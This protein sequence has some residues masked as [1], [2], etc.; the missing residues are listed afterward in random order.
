MAD[1]RQWQEGALHG[2]A[3]SGDRP[4]EPR[5]VKAAPPFALSHTPPLRSRFKRAV[6]ALVALAMLAPSLGPV[7]HAAELILDEGVVVKFGADAQLVVR[8]KLRAGAAVTLTSVNDD[9]AAGQTNPTAGTPAAGSWRGLSIEKT[10]TAFGQPALN[11]LSLRYGAGLSVRSTSPALQFMQLTDNTVGL[12]LLDGANP[13]VT[14]SSFL[15]NGIGIEALGGSVPNVTTTQFSQNTGFAITNEKPATVIQATGNWWGHASGPRDTAGNPQGQGDAVSAGVNY[16]SYLGQ[17]P[18]ISPSI[19]L[20]APAAFYATPTLQLELACVNATEYRIAENGEFAAAT[21]VPL[22]GGKAV[23]DYTASAGDGRKTI[24]VQF[25][26]A[27]GTVVSANLT[28]P[29]ATNTATVLIDSAAPVVSINNPAAGSVL[30]QPITVEASATD[31]GG[32]VK[33]VFYLDGQVVSTQTTISPSGSYSYAWNTDNSANGDHTLRVVA[34]DEAGRSS[35]QSRVATVSRTPPAPDTAGPAIASVRLDGVALADGATLSRNGITSAEVTD[36]SGVARVELL[37]DGQTIATPTGSGGQYSAPF[38]IA[39]VANG[40]HALAWRAVDSLNNVSTASYQVTVAHAAPNAPVITSPKTGLTTRTATLPVTGTAAAGSSVQLLVNGQPSGPLLTTSNGAFSGAVTLASG[41]N[42]VQARAS[43]AYGQSGLSAAVSVT[44]DATVPSGPSNLAAAALVDGKVRLTWA[45]STDPNAI[46]YDLYRLRSAFA[47]IGAATKANASPITGTSY[48]DLPKPDGA[49]FYRLVAVNSVF[50]P[51]VPTDQVQV[52]ADGTAPKAVSVV[53]QPLGKVDPATGRIGQG[54]VNVQLTVSEELQTAPYLAVVPA[55]G[56]PIVLELAKSNATTYTGAFFVD[57]STS[58]GTANALFSARDMVGN[59]GTEIGAGATLK[60][61]TEGPALSSITLNPG[62]PIKVGT[63]TTVQATFVFS[64]APKPGATPQIKYLLSGPVRQATPIAGLT[65]VDATTWKASFVLPNDAGL[66][67]PEILSF[68]S[69]A[70]DDLDNVSTRVSA[71]NR[72]QVYQGNL[73]PAG[74]PLML[75]G[76]AMPGG[77][78]SLTWQAVDEAFAYQVYRK[79]PADAALVALA[80][81]SGATHV[82][83]TPADGLYTYAVASVRSSNGEE[84]VSSQSATVDVTTIANAPGAPQNLALLLTGQGIKAT[85]QA[86]VASTVDYYNLY[87]ASG[88][89]ITSVAGLTPIKTRVKNPITYD[90]QPSPSQGAYVVTAVDAAGN[91][92]AVSNSAYLNASLLPVVNLRVEQIGNA[93]PVISWQAPNGSLSGYNVYVGPDATRTRL[94]PSPITATSFSD[95]GFSGGERRYTVASVD[96]SGQEIGRSL[97]LPAVSTQIVSGLPIKRGI[98][99]KVQA[100]VVNTSAS[101]VTNARVVV[102][103]PINREATQFADHKSEP[104]DLGSNQ[105]QL[106]TVVVGG[107]ADLPGQ[108]QAQVGLESSPNEGETVKIARNQTLDVGDSALVVGMSTGEFTRGATGKVRLTIENTS[109]VEVEFL[110]ATAGGNNPSS[111]LRFKILDADGNVLATQPYKQAVGANV[112][113]LTSGQTVARIPA[114]ASYTS[115]QFDLAVPGSSPNSIR[116]KL[117]VDKMRYHSGQDDQVVIAGRGSEKAVSLIDTAYVGEITN[118]APLSS[119]GDRDIV[120]TGR[121][122]ARGSNQPLPSTRLKLVFNQQG[123]ERVF[124]VL[125]D[126]SGAFTYTFQPTATDAGL[127]KIS[128]IHPDL[129]DRPEQRNFTINRVTFGPTPF[130]VD[131]PRNYSY[132]VP[133]IARSGAGTTATNM[134]FVLEPS[135]QPTGQLPEG[136]NL[137]LPAPA[138]IGERSQVNIPVVFSATNEALASGSIILSVYSDERPQGAG[139]PI[140]LVRINYALSE[141]KAYLVSLPSVIETGMSQGANQI[142][143]V[144]VQ[145]KGTQ[146]ALALAFTLA[147][148]DGSAVPSWVN[149]SSNADGN[150]AV[151]DKRTI[152]I[153]FKPPTGLQEGVY[154]FRLNVQGTNV[155]AQSL[156]IYASVTQS[157]KGNVLFRASDIYTAT[158]DKQGRLIPGLAGAAITLQNEDVA[159]VS[160]QLTTDALGEAYFQDIPAGRYTYRARANNHQ[161]VAG[162]LQI[163]PGVTLTQPIFLNYNLITVE[164]SVREVTIQDRYEITIDATFE[165]DVPAAVV[166]MQPSSVNLPIMNP[167]DVFY[168]ELSLTNHGLIRADGVKQQLPQSDSFF[169]YEFLVE[170]PSELRAKQRVTIPYRVIALQSLETLANAGN[171]SGG[172]CFNYSNTTRVNYDFTCTNGEQSNGTTSTSWFSNSSSSCAPGT[173]GGGGGSGGGGWGGGGGFGGIG[174]GSTSIPL[175]GRKCVATPDGKTQCS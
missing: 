73:P 96:G 18:L 25:R 107:Y 164:W 15:R 81:A 131:V 116:V 77:K 10:S 160:H 83:Q 130:K 105:T 65:A 136:I 62:A 121:A 87:R 108:A 13:A 85:W 53:Y 78:A 139:A 70:Q 60:I 34:T 32:L 57:G 120:I 3:V 102:R 7:A 106:V 24:G 55:G 2:G 54:K 127:Y 172:G 163:K 76:K 123:F 12:R 119:F 110:T 82:D 112:I 117:E 153:A 129:T 169:R 38:S 100:Q 79:G 8:D 42:Q 151:G 6:A 122:L 43:D 89:S 19:R 86:P 154:E 59:R 48:E 74:A 137:Q 155:P 30:A 93:L 1:A 21:F 140:G 61:D 80:R 152:D 146:D 173:G 133:F 41:A 46:G 50:T 111:E 159:S 11:G 72:F 36:R 68:S 150:L 118:V 51:S 44:L 171:A 125:T 63:A 109:E 141:A 167:G 98:M 56:A 95:S 5:P 165:T 92:S 174:G 16:S 97:N 67:S 39:G 156:N 35:E 132:P 27:A 14:G 158:L 58:S 135:A 148:P 75:T 52:V 23:V 147:K 138:S 26:N 143:S 66:A 113:T 64:K 94:T 37:L 45:R 168:G 99:N 71:A 114:G 103:L 142:E 84:T 47:D 124:S 49:W 91:E 31:A 144:T 101:A 161:E 149:L 28:N 17:A 170:V 33:V 22:A 157:G 9:A 40:S 69:Q 162:R 104:F 88:T 126:A 145:N 29:A 175:S 134:R 20:V 128:A 90:P 115:D 166:V 4:V